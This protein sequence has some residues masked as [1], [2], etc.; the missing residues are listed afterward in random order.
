MII[1]KKNTTFALE[2]SKINHRHKPTDPGKWEDTNKDKYPKQP[3][4]TYKTTFIK[5]KDK[6]MILKESEERILHTEKQG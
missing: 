4:L 2:V 1:P 3:Q 6:E 5:P